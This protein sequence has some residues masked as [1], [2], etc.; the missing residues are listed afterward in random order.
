ML[1]TIFIVLCL[2]LFVLVLMLP[3]DKQEEIFRFVGRLFWT[4]AVGCGRLFGCIVRLQFCRR[5]WWYRCGMESD[6]LVGL[7]CFCGFH[8]SFQLAPGLPSK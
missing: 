3:E 7:C 6:S 4:A 1:T 8:A 2:I 5:F